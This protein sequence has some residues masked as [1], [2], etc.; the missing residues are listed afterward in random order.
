MYNTFA[1]YNDGKGKSN[2]TYSTYEN[3]TEESRRPNP[4]GSYMDYKQFQQSDDVKQQQPHPSGAI[5]PGAEPKPNNTTKSRVIEIT[6]Q[7]QHNQLI[8]SSPL[9]VMKVH[10]SW[11]QPCKAAAPQFEIL[12]QIYGSPQ[13]AF[14]SEDVELGFLSNAGVTGVP[15]FL[16]FVQGQIKEKIVGADMNQVE[17]K[18]VEF[19]SG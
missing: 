4:S 7:E 11:C 15:T 3:Y 19:I 6:S 1:S 14:T 9:M 13:I 10:A 18:L 8:T 12:S 16:F 2:A 17:K 5:Q